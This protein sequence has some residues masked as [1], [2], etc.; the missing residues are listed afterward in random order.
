MD[1]IFGFPQ[2]TFGDRIETIKFMQEIIKWAQN[3]TCIIFYLYQGVL[4]K[5]MP[6]PL[7]KEILKI[8]DRWEAERKIFGCWRN[9]MRL[10][11][12]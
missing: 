9:Q 7:G 8:L 11:T 12:L 4:F 1:I 3:H 10:R 5:K 2:E 6:A